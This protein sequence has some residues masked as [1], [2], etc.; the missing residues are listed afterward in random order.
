MPP[1]RKSGGP[2]KGIRG[3]L[4][5]SAVRFVVEDIGSSLSREATI[6]RIVRTSEQLVR[7]AS[8]FNSLAFQLFPGASIRWDVFHATTCGKLPP[9][10][11]ETN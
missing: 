1:T 2:C 5:S 8:S 6:S 7:V 3:F 11:L 4:A 10:S 9:V